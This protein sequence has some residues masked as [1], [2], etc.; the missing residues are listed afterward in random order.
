MRK[1][2]LAVLG[3]VALLTL[4]CRGA[5][6]GAGSRDAPPGE[7]PTLDALYAAYIPLRGD[8]HLH[9]STASFDSADCG[10]G[11]AT[12]TA[13]EQ[14]AAARKAGLDFAALTEHDRNPNQPGSRIPADQWKAALAA[15]EQARSPEFI[16]LP[17]YEWTSSQRSCFE[18]QPQ[19]PDYAHKVVILPAG[20]TERCDSDVCTT[21]AELGAFVD[22]AG[23]VILTPHPWRV[24]L[25]EPKPAGLPAYVRRD[26]FDYPGDGPDGVFVGAEVGPD[27]EPLRWK[28]LCSHPDE[29]LPSQTG[30]LAEWQQALLQGKHLAAVAS[31][32]RHFGFTPFGA[33]T[34]VLFARERTP[35]A[36]LEALQARRTMAANL[37][38]FEVRLALGGAIVGETAA[39]SVVP[40]GRQTAEQEAAHPPEGGL[41]VAAPPEQV[42]AIEVWSGDRLLKS[43]PPDAVNQDLTFALDG[44]R[45][46][47][48][49]KVTGTETDPDTGTHR[50]TITSPIW[51]RQ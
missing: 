34:T 43:F 24:V 12:F 14:L 37:E 2:T 50:T 6:D 13:A 5:N 49:A 39:E 17:G 18:E 45:G 46:P 41:R 22:K 9:S 40:T 42:A 44:E 16:T 36:I 15:V 33:R 38:P 29:D 20:S 11:C 48:W 31:S 30:T 27:F 3:A 10:P 21:P 1:P 51:T 35:A 28:A 47:I 8:L 23:G 7:P 19:R 4:A 26:Y 32:D 25:L